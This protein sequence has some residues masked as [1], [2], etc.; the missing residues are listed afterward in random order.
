ML[1]W[2]REY[3]V[4]FEKVFFDSWL[5]TL[6]TCD[7]FLNVGLDF[8]IPC[9]IRES[10]LRQLAYIHVTWFCILGEL[11]L[12]WTREYRVQLEKGFFGSWL[13]YM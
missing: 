7:M 8:P 4:Q 6:V 13:T 2:T 3:R 9:A 1:T 12:T 5:T 10:V 11:M